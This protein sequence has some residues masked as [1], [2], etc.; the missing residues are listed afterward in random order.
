MSE[1]RLIDA[2]ALKEDI[3]NLRLFKPWVREEIKVHIDNTPTIKTFTL[4]DIEENYKK[5]L[6]KGLSEWKTERPKGRWNYIQ[7]GMAACPFCGARPH[8]DYKNFCSKCGA[9]MRGENK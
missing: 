5:G 7:P 2:N 3:N 6:E 8:E 9:D 4:L 1:Q